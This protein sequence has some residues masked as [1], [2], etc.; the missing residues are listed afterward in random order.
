MDDIEKGKA[1]RL[2]PLRKYWTR[3]DEEGRFPTILF[4]G[5]DRKLQTWF[6]NRAKMLSLN[7]RFN[8]IP[9]AE[10]EV[11]DIIQTKSPLFGWVAR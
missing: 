1:H 8:P 3:W 6:R 7:V 11:Q 4:T 2:D 10:A 9:A 5:N